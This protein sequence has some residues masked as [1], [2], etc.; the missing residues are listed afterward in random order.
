MSQNWPSLSLKRGSWLES[1]LPAV[2]EVGFIKLRFCN[3]REFRVCPS[4]FFKGTGQGV[5][6]TVVLMTSFPQVQND[7]RWATLCS[8]IRQIPRES[9]TKIK[10]TTWKFSIDFSRYNFQGIESY[11][12]RSGAVESLSLTETVLWNATWGLKVLSVFFAGTA[13][14]SLDHSLEIT[15]LVSVI[16]HS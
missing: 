3:V 2:I 16:T 4:N 15:P 1:I 5:K 14:F 10:I 6:V 7:S 13:R 8:K 12:N 11:T 9:Q